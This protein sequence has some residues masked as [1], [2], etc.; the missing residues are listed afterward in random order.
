MVVDWELSGIA[1]CQRDSWEYLT[2]GAAGVAWRLL[3]SC[4][5]LLL[6][7]SSVVDRELLASYPGVKRELGG[8][9]SRYIG[10]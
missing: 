8:S 6:G 7:S 3:E 1:H 4:S 10:S 9:G 2:W 5:K